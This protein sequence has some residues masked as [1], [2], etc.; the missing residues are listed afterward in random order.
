MSYS[1]HDAN[2]LGCRARPH[3]WYFCLDAGMRDLTSAEVDELLRSERV[4]HVA[5]VDGDDPYVGP[6]SFVYVDGVIAFRTVEGRRLAALRTNPR[7]AIE[8]TRTGPGVAD[9]AT[10]LLAGTATILDHGS[11]AA[12]YVSQI[13]AKYRAAYG[14]MGDMPEWLLDPDASLVRVELDDVS[15]RASTVERPGRL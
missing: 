1:L 6:L 9:W 14:V 2:L 5:V 12:G 13:L 10:A 3:R 11:E 8:V 15:G 4:A 7:V